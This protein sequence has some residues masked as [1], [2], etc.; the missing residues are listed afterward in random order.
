MKDLVFSKRKKNSLSFIKMQNRTF[1]IQHL[2]PYSTWFS[3]VVGVYKS[4]TVMQLLAQTHCLA[5][6]TVS[7]LN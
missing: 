5:L 2:G 1:T 4:Y 3:C 7:E 6:C